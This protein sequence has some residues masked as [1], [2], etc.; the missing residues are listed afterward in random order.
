MP[1]KKLVTRIKNNEGS[2]P[3]CNL[4]YDSFEEY[5]NNYKNN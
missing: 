3:N 5:L 2:I 4:I 1:T